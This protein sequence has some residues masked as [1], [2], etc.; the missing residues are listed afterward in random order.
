[1]HHPALEPAAGAPEFRGKSRWPPKRHDPDAI[2]GLRAACAE[3]VARHRLGAKLPRSRPAHRTVCSALSRP[4]SARRDSTS[5]FVRFAPPVPSE[6]VRMPS[7]ASS[8]PSKAVL[9]RASR[10]AV[11]GTAS[12]GRAAQRGPQRQAAR[13]KLSTG[14]RPAPGAHPR[15]PWTRVRPIGTAWRTHSA[16]LAASTIV[17]VSVTSLTITSATSPRRGPNRDYWRTMPARSR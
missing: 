9:S 14:R 12:R 10:S 4:C 11:I 15:G 7:K 8:G 16:V 3:L 5:R 1:M 2:R 6:A 17:P 13:A